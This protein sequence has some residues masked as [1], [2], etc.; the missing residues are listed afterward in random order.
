MQLP[1]E[2]PSL[3]VSFT[4]AHNNCLLDFCAKPQLNRVLDRAHAHLLIQ[5]ARFFTFLSLLGT[6]SSGLPG[7]KALGPRYMDFHPRLPMVY[8]INELSSE[9]AVFE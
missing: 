7:R 9:V 6:V 2:F 8:V 4:I 5:G 3:S 1:F